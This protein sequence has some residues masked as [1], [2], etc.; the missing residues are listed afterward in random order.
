MEKKKFDE[1]FYKLLS[2]YSQANE[3]I[4]CLNDYGEVIVFG[5]AIREFNDN[6]FNNIPRDFDI[7]IKKNNHNNTSLDELLNK[8]NYKK[9]DLMD[10]KFML[11]H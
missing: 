6:K 11:I 7:V 2:K 5:G 1:E 10:I 3:L 8:F 9:I 4:K